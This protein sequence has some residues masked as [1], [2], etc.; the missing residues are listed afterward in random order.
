MQITPNYHFRG[1][2]EEAIQL[3]K[4][5]FNGEITSV[6]KYSNADPSDLSI[7]DM[8]DEDKNLVYHAEMLI[9]G[10]RF[11][12]SDSMSDISF[13]QNTSMVVTFDTRG[14][15]MDAYNILGKDAKI[16]HPITDTTYSSCFVSLV[17]KFGMRWE[18]MTEDR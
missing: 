15:V 12:F 3:Y 9:G 16:I 1:D 10:H 6:M 17:D 13:G 2:C 11:M 18:L 8:S 7:K 4:D 14:A 5:A